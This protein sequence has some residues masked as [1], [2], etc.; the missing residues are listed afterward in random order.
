MSADRRFGSPPGDFDIIFNSA[1]M[2]SW[3]RLMK[4]QPD[5]TVM[6]KFRMPFFNESTDIDFSIFPEAFESAARLGYDFRIPTWKK[7]KFMFF[8]GKIMIQAWCGPNSTETRLIVKGSDI[9]T[10]AI[11]EY[12]IKEYES[13]LNYYN[14]VQ[15]YSV[16]HVNSNASKELG[17]CHCNDCAIENAILEEY[18]QRN[19]NFSVTD[20]IGK[21]VSILNIRL[22]NRGGK[23]GHGLVFP[24][25]T[26]SELIAKIDSCYY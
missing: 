14:S 26:N 24:D 10:N 5:S 7:G 13:K 3:S 23:V 25:L 12:D 15:R 2:Y 17:F 19:P 18:H 1:Q 8:P 22:L 21:L 4:L 9:A 16:C 11:H 6:I 20:F